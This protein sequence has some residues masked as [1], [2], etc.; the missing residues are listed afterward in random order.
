M[1]YNGRDSNGAT[2]GPLVVWT[3]DETILIDANNKVLWQYD[4]P[5]VREFLSKKMADRYVVL[6]KNNQKV[7]AD[8]RSGKLFWE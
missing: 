5:F 7:W 1:Q 2:A 6:L 3:E 8:F 4:L